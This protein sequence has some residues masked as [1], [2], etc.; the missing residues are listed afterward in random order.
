MQ[1][2]LKGTH[3]LHRLAHYRLFY[4]LTTL[5]CPEREEHGYFY[6]PAFKCSTNPRV[7]TAHRWSAVDVISRMSKPTGV[8][9]LL[10]LDDGPNH[11]H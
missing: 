8:Y 2:F 3:T 10:P 5:W 1:W 4:A 9:R 6:S 11:H 7:A